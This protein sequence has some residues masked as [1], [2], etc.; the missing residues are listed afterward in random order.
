MPLVLAVLA[1]LAFVTAGAGLLLLPVE[2]TK[3]LHQALYGARPER[4]APP[5]VR[6]LGPLII[7]MVQKLARRGRSEQDEGSEDEK[8]A[9]LVAQAGAPFGWGVREWELVRQMAMGAGAAIVLIGVVAHDMRLMVAGA[10]VTLGGMKGIDKYLH[11]K[12][13]RRQALL[14]RQIPD[15]AD[16][17]ASITA[18][19]LPLAAALERAAA[20][21]PAPLGTEL[22][23]AVEAIRNGVPAPEALHDMA[24]RIGGEDLKHLVDAMVEAQRSGGEGLAR[25]MGE[26]AEM[27]RNIYLQT[28]KERIAGLKGKMIWVLLAA[29]APILVL[30]FSMFAG[31]FGAMGSF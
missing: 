6:S 15:L 22:G 2:R 16:V 1:G 12:I 17:V 10:A 11:T 25:A 4:V 5:T 7:A 31:N 8:L 14:Q 19:G 9:E 3:A 26:Q 20:S 24:K 29:A 18:V 30:M 13:A 27:Y 21:I 23:Q 28:Q